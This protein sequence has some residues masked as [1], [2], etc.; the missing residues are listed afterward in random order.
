V[1]SHSGAVPHVRPGRALVLRTDRGNVEAPRV[2]LV[3][4]AAE[5]REYVEQLTLEV[6]VVRKDNDQ[7]ADC[8]GDGPR[9]EDLPGRLPR[10]PAVGGPG[11]VGSPP[12]ARAF[13]KACWLVFPLGGESSRSQT[14]YTN[15]ESFGSAVIEFLSL[16]TFW[17]SSRMSVTGFSQ[18]APWLVER[19]TSMAF[20]EVSNPPGLVPTDRLIR[21]A[22]PFGE[23][24]SHGS[25]ARP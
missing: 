11:E 25:E 21:Y 1:T 18:V 19:I 3:L 12:K 20:G 24:A 7:V 4:R 6:L 23:M 15:L 22:V 16:R 17:L 5:L 13:S 2:V 10:L 9:L 8:L 14:A